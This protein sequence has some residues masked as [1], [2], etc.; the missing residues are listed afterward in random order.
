MF[1]TRLKTSWLL[2]ALCLATALLSYPAQAQTI[3]ATVSGVVADPTGAVVPNATVKITSAATGQA[4]TVTTDGEGRYTV[5]FLQPGEY[6]ITVEAT[7]FAKSAR[8]R[9]TL[10]VAQV[11]TLDFKLTIGAATDVV[12]ITGDAPLLQTDQPA[13]ESTIENKLIEDL[14]SAQ[15]STLA[16]INSLP[17]VIDAGFA[18][19]QGENLNTNGNAQGPI[20]SPGNRNFF[21][22]SFTVGGGQNSTNDVLLDGVSN[23]VGDFNGVA[24]NPPPDSVREF[25]VLSGAF[26]AEYG[27]SGGGVVNMITKAGGKKYH[28]SLYEYFQNGGLNANG[29]QRNRS[30]QLANGA[31]VLPRIPIKR[32]QFGAAI[33]GPIWLPKKIFGPA[34][35]ENREKTFF[36]FN[37]EGRRERNP[38]SRLL[39]LPTARMRRGD[40]SEL[41]TSAT[42]AGQTDISGAASLF[43]QLY[44]PFEP[45]VGGK[46]QT[47]A[48]NRLD[49]LPVCGAGARASACLDPVALKIL[50]YLPLPNQ[51]GLADNY[52]VSDIARFSRDLYAIRVDQVVSEKHSF[53]GRYSKEHRYQAEP[54]FLGSVATNSRVIVDTFHNATLND[55][56]SIKPN[57]I[58]NVRY[59][60]TRAR[61]HQTP[62]SE[63]FD[64]GQLGF[65][66]YILATSPIGAFPILSFEAG[67]QGQG[68]PSEITASQI[69]G[70]G[71]NQPRDTQTVADA[72]TWLKGA[73]T[74]K[75]GAEFRLLRFFA[76]QY[77]NPA[78]T[79]SFARG[80]TRGPNPNTTPT[81]ILETGSSFASFLLGI[82]S[83]AS[84][85]QVT[86]ITIYHHYYAGFVQD[87][88][89][90]TR[91]L[92]LNLGLRWDYETGTAETHGLIS[93]FDPE[94]ASHLKGKVTAPADPIVRALRP[95]FTDLRGLVSFPDGPQT[96]YPKKRFAPR[97]G[98]AYRLGGKTVLRGG[99][100][101][102]FVPYSVE[103]TSAIGNVFSV[104]AVQG[105]DNGQVRQPGGAAA[106]TVF[107]TNPYPNGI[108]SP[109]GRALGPDTLIGQSPVLVEPFRKNAYLQQWNFVISRQL[110]RSLVLDVAYAGNHGVRLPY[111]TLN[112]NQIPSEHLDYAKAHF[113][114]AKDVNGVAATSVSQFFSQ[115]V[116]N[117]FFGL[118]TNPNS[119]LRTANVTRGQLLKLYPQYDNPAIFNGHFGASKYNSLQV[120][121][122]KRFSQGLSANASYV[123]GKLIDIGRNGNNNS[124][125]ATSVEDAFDLAGEYSISSLDVPHRFVASFSYELPFG[126]RKRFGKDWNGLVNALAGGWQVSGTATCQSGTP[127]SISGAGIGLGYATRRANRLPGD[128]SFDD[129]RDR[130]RAGLTWFNTAVFAQPDDFTLGNAARNYSDVRRDGYRNVDL[131]LLKNFLWNEGRQKIQFRGE[132]INAFNIVVFG[133]PNT[134]VNDPANFGIVR[135]QGNQPR[136]IQLVLR[137]TF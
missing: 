61:A 126:R 81:N 90:A 137:Y 82:P 18:L 25:K 57:L 10:E 62:I 104:S 134:S 53:F 27:R 110:A 30:G 51:P 19:A 119:A 121:L 115:S 6:G 59:G 120:K 29:F 79:Y 105:F 74:F 32:N 58:N 103:Q 68:R 35:Y 5:A 17:G 22:S 40:L 70:S 84:K 42:R 71:N 34:G 113:A 93:N 28:G 96:E 38:F 16:F 24:V 100:G 43:G 20:G 109:P 122:E 125:T 8:N 108:T 77:N 33:G 31:D 7:G 88:W 21:D 102:F 136:L 65:P 26:S 9:V 14:P 12:E 116:A 97:V 72:V 11:A 41:L 123:W 135:T 127:L 131:S 99:Y 95:N 49:T 54:T 67:G 78:G 107:L 106:P 85:E 94:A 55:V 128:G 2:P 124:S 92:T 86:P 63:G 36:F 13:L 101:V 69:G 117:P 44:D 80:Q 76:F 118:I 132:F 1:A 3:T 87:D 112:I 75:F 111:R 133:T 46:R 56:Y 114:E 98:L 60:Y 130:A 47:F 48:G 83:S 89:K 66:S 129:A 23:T 52:V 64:P 91:N 15:R 39:T 73:H 45:L 37:Y 50:E 4:K